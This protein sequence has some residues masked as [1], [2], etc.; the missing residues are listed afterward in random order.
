MNVRVLVCQRPCCKRGVRTNAGRA[1]DAVGAPKRKLEEVDDALV[2]SQKKALMTRKQRKMYEG[3][4]RKEAEN[5]ARV[6]ELERKRDAA[7]AAAVAATS[8]E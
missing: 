4:R 7:A 3:L 2:D 1:V 6:A 5:A 8:S